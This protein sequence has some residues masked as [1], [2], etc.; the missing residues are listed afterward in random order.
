MRV[1]EACCGSQMMWFDKSN[2][3]A[4]FVDARTESHV[5]CDGRSLVISP[6]IECN[7]TKLPCDDE[8]FYHVVFDPPHMD[9]LGANTWMAK[10]YGRLSDGWESDIKAGFSECF[11]VLKTNGT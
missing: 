6:D 2:S 11:R 7:F 8:T 5:L 4:V 9:S 1:L 10:K 3:S